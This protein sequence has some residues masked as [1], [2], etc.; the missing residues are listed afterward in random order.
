M[1]LVRG[2]RAYAFL[3]W[4]SDGTVCDQQIEI[5]AP[6]GSSC[7]KLDFPI[8]GRPCRTRELRLGADG[9]V[10]QK[11]PG[12]REASPTNNGVFTCTLRYWPAALR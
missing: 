5:V 4:E 7:G 6:S 2:R 9:T 8:D 1:E 3:P 10:L 11:M 12:D